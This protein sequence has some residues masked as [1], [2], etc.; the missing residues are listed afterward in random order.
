MFKSLKLKLIVIIAVLCTVSLLI[1]SYSTLRSVEKSTGNLLNESYNIRTEYFASQIHSWLIDGTATVKAVET[2]VINSE[3]GGSTDSIV[4]ALTDC[5][6]NDKLAAMVYVQMAD[7]L[8]LNGSGWVPPE[9]FDGRTRVWYEMAVDAKG[10]LCYSSPYVDANTGDLIVTVSKYFNK[11]GWEGVAALDVY[12]DTLL[13]D[14]QLLAQQSGEEGAY[15]FVTGADDSM[16]YHPNQ[17]FR[18]T[19]DKILTVNDLGIDYAGASSSD[20]AGVIKDYDGTP[21]YVTQKTIPAVDWHVFYVSPARNFDHVVG[22]IRN[23]MTIIFIICLVIALV[24]AA[25]AGFMVATPITE[26]SGKIKRLSEDVKEGRADLSANIRTNAKDELGQLV[27]AVNDLKNAMGDIIKNVTVASEELTRS[28]KSLN[29]AAARTSDNVSTISAAMEEMSASSEETSASTSIVTQQVNDITGLTEKV[30]RNAAEKTGQIS[31]SLTN[32]DVRKSEIETND[33]NMMSRLN[34]AIGRLRERISDTKKVEEI[35]AM[36][37]GI[38]DVATQTNLLSLNASIEAARAG[39]AGRGFAVVADEIGNLANNSANMAGNIQEVSDE[40]LAI[41]EQLVRAA[42]E[43]SE[44]MLQISRENS[45]EKKVLID[46]YI[47]TLNECYT[48][49]SAIS[50]DNQEISEGVGKIRVSISAIDTAVEENAHGVTSVAEGAG[51]LVAASDEV[52]GDAGSIERVSS[53]LMDRVG[54]FIY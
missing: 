27:Q 54:G 6:E 35:R 22:D 4:K 10:E 53:E 3:V 50:A 44:I 14:I 38:S 51:E 43:V 40:V 2:T 17:E 12:I 25:V 21:V 45:E 13:S 23:Q 37:Q 46:E 34:A 33:E 30:S 5:T 26:A 7:G 1:Q 48:A 47:R 52:L 24:V 16:I 42:E 49:M 15:V 20:D 9:D 29:G 8:F 28:A 18:S 19:V 11:N 32:I 31:D 36:T 41:V 39:E